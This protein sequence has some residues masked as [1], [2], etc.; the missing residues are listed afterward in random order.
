MKHNQTDCKVSDINPNLRHYAQQLAR[1][2]PPSVSRVLKTLA[3]NT[4]KQLLHD[5][6]VH[7]IEL[8]MQNEELRQAQVALEA[9][10]ARYF[11][12]YELAPV[13]YLSLNDAGLIM[14]ANLTAGDLLGLARGELLQ[15][16]FTRFIL[17][18]DQDRFYL[19]RRQLLLEAKPPA[20]ELRMRARDGQYFWA[21]LS[22]N[23]SR[24]EGEDGTL[25]VV[26]A[27]ISES[28]QAAQKLLDAETLAESSVRLKARFLT[29]FSHQIR[30]PMNVII[31]FS[32][33]LQM[34]ENTA[35]MRKFLRYIYSASR[36]L[37]DTLETLLDFSGLEQDIRT[38]SES[39]NAA[40]LPGAFSD[41]IEQG[42]SNGR[43]ASG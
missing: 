13:A 15:Q 3:P 19:Y 42:D 11:D 4:A 7:Q 1:A 16:P 40:Q 27:D 17:P 14:A 30:T 6:Q 9:A 5:L 33:L 20:L 41:Q 34:N 36:Q 35:D 24:D 12:L 31:G 26:V 38:V 39:S 32:E 10:R 8:E 37:H 18:D 29:N 23:R 43:K 28:K 21:R 25:R 2:N 22:A